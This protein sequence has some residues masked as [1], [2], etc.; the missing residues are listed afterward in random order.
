MPKISVIVA[1]Y[2]AEK[3][4]GVMLDCLKLQTF[5]D[6]EIVVNDD[7]STDNTIAFV[8]DVYMNPKSAKYDARIRIHKTFR[9]IGYGGGNVNDALSLISPDSKYVFMAAGDDAMT[10]NYLK[11]LYDAAEESQSDITAL[12]SH[13]YTYDRNFTIPGRVQILKYR[14]NIPAPRF[15]SDDIIERLQTDYIGCLFP[16]VD[17]IKLYRH[18]FLDN[19]GIYFPRV[20]GI[21]DF[22]FNFAQICLAKKIKIAIGTGYVYRQNPESVMHVS[23]E[24]HLR[25]TVDCLTDAVEYIEKIFS[26]KTIGE[27]SRENQLICEAHAISYIL[28][29]RVLRYGLPITDIDKILLETTKSRNATDPEVTRVLIQA[30]TYVLSFH[31]Y[32]KADRKQL[33]QLVR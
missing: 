23:A 4:V 7:C 33:F 9:N 12:N 1:T 21:E 28:Q 30:L 2:N 11:D 18:D 16:A 5:T 13:Y 29:E 15:L 32:K 19:S 8:Q 3:S 24:K 27:I 22:L 10:E 20:L 31:F 6:F 26:L 25:N 14:P 17:W